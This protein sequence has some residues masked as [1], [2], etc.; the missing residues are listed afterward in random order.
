[1]RVPV[2]NAFAGH[3]VDERDSLLQ[4]VLCTR[5]V[6]DVDGGADSIQDDSQAAPELPVALAVLETLPMRF[7]RG[8]VRCHVIVNLRKPLILTQ[9]P[10]QSSISAAPTQP[11]PVPSPPS[12]ICR[13]RS[14]RA[15]SSG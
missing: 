10:F 3:L 1:G 5:H 11:R 13:S 7:E 2:N 6:V 15:K 12:R 9:W 4:P 8:F 14:P